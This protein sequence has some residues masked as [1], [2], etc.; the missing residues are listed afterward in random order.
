MDKSA[1]GFVLGVF[2]AFV[3]G[4]AAWGSTAYAIGDTRIVLTGPGQCPPSPAGIPVTPDGCPRDTDGDGIPDYMDECP[5]SEP[6]TT[7][8]ARGC[9][10]GAG[11]PHAI[12]INLVNDE[13]DWDSAE[14][15]PLMKQRLDE[16]AVEI[17]AHP[18]ITGLRIIG[19]TDSTGAAAYNQELSERRA[20]AVADYL[21]GRGLSALRFEVSGKGATSPL[22]SNATEEGRA[23]NR[24]VEIFTLANSDD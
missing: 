1:S 15:K 14:L 17:L 6:G 12:V 22:E 11:V 18:E 3:V 5:D 21:S 8:C 19:H 10:A 23:Q 13:F 7:V 20:Q 16:A 4:S 2:F 24:R 9:P